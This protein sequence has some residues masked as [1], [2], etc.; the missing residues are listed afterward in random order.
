MHHWL[1]AH[2]LLFKCGKRLDTK[3]GVWLIFEYG[4]YSR[5]HVQQFDD[6]VPLFKDVPLSE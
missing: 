4:P 5:V 1:R 3:K 2:V 6:G